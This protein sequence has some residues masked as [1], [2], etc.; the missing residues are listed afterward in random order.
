[1]T[2]ERERERQRRERE[3]EE[4]EMVQEQIKPIL[5]GIPTMR[6]YPQ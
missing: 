5:Q 6:T 2:T 1:M 4:R 3:R